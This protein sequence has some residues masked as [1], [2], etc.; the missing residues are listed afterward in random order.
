MVMRINAQLGRDYEVVVEVK[1]EATDPTHA[2]DI[3]IRALRVLCNDDT[4][5]TTRTNRW[6]SRDVVV[7]HTNIL[8]KYGH[9]PGVID[10]ILHRVQL[11]IISLDR[12]LKIND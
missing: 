1:M 6:S 2:K 7:A 11:G 5:V 9:S 12:S 10:N 4:D 8:R 3:V